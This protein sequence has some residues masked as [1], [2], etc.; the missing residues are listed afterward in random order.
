MIARETLSDEQRRAEV[1]RALD[2][3]RPWIEADGGGVEVVEISPEGFVLVRLTGNCEGCSAA[4]ITIKDGILN[5]LQSQI[6]WITGVEAVESDVPLE[7]RT[8][9]DL[10][11]RL[12]AEQ[13]DTEEL[14]VA[15]DEAV[16]LL[17]PEWELPGEVP[18][19]REHTES[20]V[21]PQLA[22]EEECVFPAVEKYLGPDGGPVALMR[23]EHEHFWVLFARFEC[24]VDSYR[25]AEQNTRDAL[26]RATRA[27]T[28]HLTS[29]FV[30]ERD[31][32]FRLLD[33]ALPPESRS[34]LLGEL[35]RFVASAHGGSNA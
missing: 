28:R 33:Y 29:H 4:G 26:K 23:R 11:G 2:Q 1:E 5:T 21:R 10:E 22:R 32:V 15:L 31:S 25:P 9:P 6:S 8:G 7:Q 17:E 30:K 3:L 24:A 19:W 20:V 27:M 35:T 18:R 16:L 14:L 13:R 12:V 34:E